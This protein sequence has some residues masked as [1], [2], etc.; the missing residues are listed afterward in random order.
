MTSSDHMAELLHDTHQTS[1]DIS[2]HSA[3]III[4]DTCCTCMHKSLYDN[5]SMVSQITVFRVQYLALLNTSVVQRYLSHNPIQINTA[6]KRQTIHTSSI[7]RYS[8]DIC[9]FV[10]FFSNKHTGVYIYQ[11]RIH[12]VIEV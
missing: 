7:R 8:I 5:F 9:H 4:H 6:C 11:Y 2:H 1:K 10:I 12:G 3:C